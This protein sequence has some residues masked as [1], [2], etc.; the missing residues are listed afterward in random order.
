VYEG[1][2]PEQLLLQAW[3]DHGPSVRIS[4]PEERRHGGFLGFFTKVTYRIEVEPVPPSEVDGA[5]HNGSAAEGWMPATAD[6]VA[7]VDGASAALADGPAAA[8]AETGK[9]LAHFADATEDVLEL[10]GAPPPTFDK[11]LE[12]VASSLGEEPG[13]YQPSLVGTTVSID[14]L[15]ADERPEGTAPTGAGATPGAA[16][17][18]GG[19]HAGGWAD[20]PGSGSLGHHGIGNRTQRV[21]AT[22][23]A[24]RRM[25]SVVDLLRNAGYPEALLR[26][27]EH[28]ADTE[29]TLEAAFALLPAA[30]APPRA[31]GSLIAVAGPGQ[32]A[33][34]AAYRLAGEL[35][36]DESLVA[37]ASQWRAARTL[38]PDMFVRD[39]DEAASLS[40]GWRRDRVGLVA[41]TAPLISSDHRWAREVLRAMR[42]SAVWGVVSATTKPEDV[43]QWATALGGFDALVLEDVAYTSTPA[44]VLGTGIPVAT[45]DGR[46]ATP[47]RWAAAVAEL[48]TPD[49]DE[50]TP[51]GTGGSA[52]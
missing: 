37:M 8:H 46:T 36:L 1:P 34:E 27:L 49:G 40:P 42:P 50:T 44:A 20:E 15:L 23:A 28:F 2:D 18:P 10:T 11:V 30:P 52:R 6:G 14:D 5:A 43:V 47:A 3:S 32:A 21:L 38:Q 17:E 4:E 24:L 25:A 12:G 39:P 16:G 35:G 48:V 31:P 33:R 22:A 45:L 7:E 9:A 51:G 19:A 26:P 29:A 41:V 13:F